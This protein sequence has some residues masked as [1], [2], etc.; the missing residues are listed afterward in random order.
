[1]LTGLP[2]DGFS[3]TLA[4]AGQRLLRARRQG[5]LGTVRAKTGNLE[6]VVALAGVAYARNG[7]LLSFAVMADRMKACPRPAAR[8]PASPSPRRLRLPIEDPAGQ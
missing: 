2:V 6:T 1:M 5:R 4:R 3:G 7:Q 8:W